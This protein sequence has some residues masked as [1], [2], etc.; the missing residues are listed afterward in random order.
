MIQISLIIPVFNGEL[1]IEKCI[2]S[3]INQDIKLVNYEIIIINDGSTDQTSEILQG[4]KKYSNVKIVSQQNLGLGKSRNEGLKQA[5]GKYLWFIDS[6]DWIAENCLG[7]LILKLDG[8]DIFRLL[9]TEVNGSLNSPEHMLRKENIVISGI[10]YMKHDFKV[11]VPFYIFNREFLLK[12]EL[13]F[14]PLIFEDFEFT[15]R[16][17]FF[18]K[19]LKNLNCLVY[20]R[21]IRSDS[22]MRT[23][24]VHKPYHLLEI[25][26]SLN[27]FALKNVK[28]KEEYIFSRLISLAINNYLNATLFLDNNHQMILN[29]LIYKNKVLFIHLI[30]SKKIKYII[31]GILFYLFPKKTL[32]LYKTLNYKIKN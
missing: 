21:L 26:F 31:E 19:K 8:S 20:F 5:R 7:N 11:C 27:S 12:N 2:N 28:P 16:V 15:P 23:V 6:D 14:K 22:I 24:S 18:T 13:E 1:Y 4:F 10:D 29:N 32:F 17:L 30:K 3:C 9:S 25:I